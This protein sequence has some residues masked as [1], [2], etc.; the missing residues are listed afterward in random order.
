MGAQSGMVGTVTALDG[1][2]LERAVPLTGRCLLANIKKPAVAPPMVWLGRSVLDLFRRAD[3]GG[4]T[5]AGRRWCCSFGDVRRTGCLFVCKDGVDPVA[6]SLLQA[7]LKLPDGVPA[8]RSNTLGD[9]ELAGAI[10]GHEPEIGMGN[11]RQ[12]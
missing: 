6:H 1:C 7:L 4:G 11:C 5:L 3:H 9:G 2:V 8:H 10:D 12:T